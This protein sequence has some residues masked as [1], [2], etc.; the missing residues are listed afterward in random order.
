MF[1]KHYYAP[2]A[3]DMHRAILKLYADAP[4]KNAA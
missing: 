3:A 4:L 2:S 1:G